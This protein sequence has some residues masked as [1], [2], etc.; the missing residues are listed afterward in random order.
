MRMNNRPAIIILFCFVL[1]SFYGAGAAYGAKTSK[2][3]PEMKQCGEVWN[4]K[5][6]ADAAKW[7]SIAAKQDYAEAQRKLGSLYYIGQGVQKDHAKAA[8]WFRKAAEQGYANA[9]LALGGMYVT[10]KGVRQDPNEAVKWYRKAAEQENA[11]A[12]LL[13]SAMYATGQGVMQSG[14]AAADWIYKAGIA[15]LKEKGKDKALTCVERI[16]DLKSKLDL[17]VPNYFLAEQLIKKIY[18]GN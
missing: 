14:A 15:Y 4:A 2:I 3:S 6:W 9:Q 1:L 11:D 17:N 7:C 5:H 13:L 16:Q 10:G 8:K 18:G 12:R